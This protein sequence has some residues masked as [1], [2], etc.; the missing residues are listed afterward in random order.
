MPAIFNVESDEAHA[1]SK[2]AE[3]VLKLVGGP[4]QIVETAMPDGY[5]EL[6]ALDTAPLRNLG[7]FP[8]T[9]LAAG[10]LLTYDWLLQQRPG[11]DE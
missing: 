5:A 1:L 10:M 6:R 2:V 11:V 4:S 9:S 3:L 8:Q 7:W